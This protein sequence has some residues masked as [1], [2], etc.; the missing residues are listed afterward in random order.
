MVAPARR[1]AVQDPRIG[2]CIQRTDAAQTMNESGTTPPDWTRWLHG[3]GAQGANLI[4]SI[5]LTLG[6]TAQGRDAAPVFIEAW[7]QALNGQP[8]DADSVAERFSEAVHEALQRMRRDTQAGMAAVDGALSGLHEGGGDWLSAAYRTARAHGTESP[9]AG[10]LLAAFRRFA[11]ALTAF[12]AQLS[13]S[14]E[15]GLDAFRQA[16]DQRRERGE[17]PA[18]LVELHRLWVETA[19]PAYE[20]V[21]E[22]DEYAQAFSALHN[23]AMALGRTAQVFAQPILEA[24]GL[25]GRAEIE[26]LRRQMNA[27]RRERNRSQRLEAEL[28][29]LRQEVQALRRELHEAAV[30]RGPGPSRDRH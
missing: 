8:A 18:D 19:E 13:R 2:G 25:P 14:V 1:A 11:E 5:T 3:A 4:R 28:S 12:Q 22:S 17:T 30:A 6:A 9:D 27:L 29:L 16:L 20:R 7:Q 10:T 23:A 21:L 24:L 15:A 26:G